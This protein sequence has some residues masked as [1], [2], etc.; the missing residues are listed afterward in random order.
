MR[1]LLRATL[2]VASLFSINSFAE[3]PPQPPKV[4]ASA[5]AEQWNNERVAKLFKSL[6]NNMFPPSAYVKMSIASYKSEVLSKEL[7][8]EFFLKNGNVLIEILAPQVEKGKYILKTE[9]DLW[10]YFTR[11]H[12]S[13]RLASRDSFMGTD[14]NNYDLL[15]LNLVDDY[16][17]ENYEVVT[18]DGKQVV[19]TQLVAKPESEGYARITS[20]IDP[21]SKQII[22][23]DCFAI[24]GTMIKTISYSKYKKIGDFNVPTLT[25]IENHIEKGRHSTMHFENIEIDDEIDEFMFS[26]GYLESLN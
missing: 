16:I 11:I 2:V 13:I 12:R 5:S 1:N 17:I 22:K 9:K 7:L 23:N 15:K 6:E 3:T 14:A 25:R 18:L 10:M 24:S 26:L 19:R 4:E 21:V 20:Y 8:V